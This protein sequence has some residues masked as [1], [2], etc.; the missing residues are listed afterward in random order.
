[1]GGT[2]QAIAG[3]TDS[4]KTFTATVDEAVKSSAE[5]GKRLDNRLVYMLEIPAIHGFL[6]DRKNY[7]S[8]DTQQI[9]PV[10]EA[11]AKFVLDPSFAYRKRVQEI[12][13]NNKVETAVLDALQE[14]IIISTG[15]SALLNNVISLM[16]RAF[17]EKIRP[18][19]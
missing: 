7:P 18:N 3:D 2:L 13:P 4:D 11:Y 16:Q 1:M 17:S 10:A 12:V 9:K 19:L 5:L 8:D 6:Y 15:N 14:N